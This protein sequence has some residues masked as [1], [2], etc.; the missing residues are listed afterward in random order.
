M[1]TPILNLSLIYTNDAMSCKYRK[2]DGTGRL[3]LERLNNDLSK[4]FDP[5]PFAL[6]A[7]FAKNHNVSAHNPHLLPGFSK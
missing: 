3:D 2:N 4:D 1:T 5:L 7:V 6:L